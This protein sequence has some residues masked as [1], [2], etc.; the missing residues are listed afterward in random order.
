MIIK[1]PE[2]LSK[3]ILER[4]ANYNP[5]LLCDGMSALGIPNEGCMDVGILPIDPGMSVIGT[6][7]T[8]ETSDGDNYP[9]HMMAYEENEGYVLVIDGKGFTD[10]AYFGDMILSAAKEVGYLGVVVDGMVR[11]RSDCIELGLPVFCR[12]FI[13]RGPIKQNPGKINETVSCGGITVSPGDLIVGGADGVTVVPRDRIE[14]VFEKAEVKRQY[15][16]N[17]IKTIAE[18]HE[19]KRNGKKTIELAPDWVKK[20]KESEK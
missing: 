18:Y 1:K 15:E 2:K 7:M 4:A 13:Q 20:I 12:G 17:R 9:I 6:A 10:R 8:I 19:S 3:E 16:E 11:D 5:A 14:E